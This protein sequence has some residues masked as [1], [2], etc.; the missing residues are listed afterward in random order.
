MY[1]YHLSAFDELIRSGLSRYHL[2]DFRLLL[3]LISIPVPYVNLTHE[4][5][6]T[7]LRCLWVNRSMLEFDESKDGLGLLSF[8]R[9]GR[10]D[11]D[12]F[13]L[14]Q[15]RS[16][17]I[18]VDAYHQFLFDFFNDPVRSRSYCLSPMVFDSAASRCRK[19]ICQ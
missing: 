6:L 15:H 4:R 2:E 19:F 5:V 14:G 16:C 11:D 8:Y 18:V 9:D 7:F 3:A 13:R 10:S 1:L 12:C 17:D